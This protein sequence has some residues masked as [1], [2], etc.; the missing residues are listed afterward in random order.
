VCN[1]PPVGREQDPTLAKKNTSGSMSIWCERMMQDH[2]KDWSDER[3]LNLKTVT[4]FKGR[5]K[6]SY[7]YK[8]DW[9]PKEPPG[10]NAKRPRGESKVDITSKSTYQF[11]R[12][13]LKKLR[14]K[15][16]PEKFSSFILSAKAVAEDKLLIS[17]QFAGRQ[18][19]V[20][21]F[22][23]AKDLLISLGIGS[24]SP[25]VAGMMITNTIEPIQQAEAHKTLKIIEDHYCKMLSLPLADPTTNLEHLVTRLWSHPNTKPVISLSGI[26]KWPETLVEIVGETSSDVA[27]RMDQ[28]CR[29]TE[30]EQVQQLFCFSCVKTL[31][32]WIIKN[33]AELRTH[34]NNAKLFEF[35]E[36]IKNGPA[37]SVASPKRS[38]RTNK[39]NKK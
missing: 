7:C 35:F 31:L 14:R 2:C 24:T 1:F 33:Q 13:T 6:T 38:L 15:W 16:T 27:T 18:H 37:T 9:I 4:Q 19:N 36:K 3:N 23:G 10:R 28:F 30:Q 5:T 26:E 22:Y 34:A 29:L 20:S 25:I 21:K 8:L 11:D 32:E 39:G 12:G 17:F